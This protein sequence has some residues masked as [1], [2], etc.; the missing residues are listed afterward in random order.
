ML[1]FVL[2]WYGYL[3]F[4]AFSNLLFIAFL[5]FPLP[6]NLLF[7]IRNWIAIPIGI[8]L[9]Y[10]DTW[11][12]SFSTVLSQGSL[13]KQ[14]SFDYLMELTAN[15]INLKM[16][17]VAFLLLVAYLFIEQWLRISVFIIAGVLWLN[18]DG[19]THFSQS[20]VPSVLANNAVSENN[21]S[22]KEE[23][24]S[25]S[26]SDVLV[27]KADAESANSFSLSSEPINSSSPQSLDNWLT[28]FYK[29]E[30]KRMTTFPT[31]LSSDAQPFDILI[32]N[33]CSLS[34]ADMAAVG[35]QGHPLWGNFDVLFKQFNSVSSYSG[36]ASLRLLRASCGQGRHSELYDPTDTQCLLMDNLAS[37][38]FTKELAL[39]HNGKFGNY[40]QEIQQLGDLNIEMQDQKGLSYQLTAFDGSKI[41]N[42]KET[43]SR[44]LQSREQSKDKRSVTFMNFVTL[45][46]G[47]RFKG[48]N[49]TADYGKRAVTLLDN[50]NNFI[51]ELDKKG[52]KV[53]VVVIPEHGA[54]LQGDKT[55]MSG[56]RDIP[57]QR[58]TTV[59]VGI[60]FTGIEEKGPRYSPTIVNKP[61]S[62]LAI[63]EFISR[64]VDGEVF[65]QSTID[66]NTLIN[67]LPQTEKVNENQGTTVVEYQ[68]Q[69]YIKLGE[70]GEWI[71]YPN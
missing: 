68:N 19:I 55:Q 22:N 15:F 69:S 10:H 56:L 45:H 58:I 24:N 57:S 14:F 62:Y 40:L 20:M 33:I 47:N 36:P 26:Q 27:D 11:L 60:R 6:D 8:I 39:D 66:W 51:N 42:D 37:L 23:I 61:S 17:G 38:G 7:K 32:I 13:L 29:G 25:A 21:I 35:L 44:W 48:E 18:I 34:T 28:Q 30:K 41:Y 12:P 1:K 63:S 9:F 65:K 50:L 16:I 59:P 49:S 3:N 4:D 2:L 43:L 53:M 46:D 70:Q 54:A 5:I 71:H 64:N 31:K 52:R 67:K